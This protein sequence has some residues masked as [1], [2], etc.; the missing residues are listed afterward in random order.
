M[1]ANNSGALLMNILRQHLDLCVPPAFVC[2]VHPQRFRK[3]MSTFSRFLDRFSHP[4]AWLNYSISNSRDFPQS[5]ERP[6]SVA[7]ITP[8]VRLTTWLHCS[9]AP[10]SNACRILTPH[11]IIAIS[12]AS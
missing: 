5:M 12:S 7:V 11:V 10:F 1:A 4:C 2:V 8:K 6:G 9:R 3:L